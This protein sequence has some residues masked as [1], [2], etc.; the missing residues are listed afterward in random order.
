M[1]KKIGKFLE[2]VKVELKKTSWPTRQE[3]IDATIVVIIA[4]AI[5]SVYVGV[6]DVFLS[7]IVSLVIK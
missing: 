1:F 3:L 7:K 2:E 5:L 4:I 6:V